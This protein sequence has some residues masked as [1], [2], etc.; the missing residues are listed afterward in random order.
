MNLREKMRNKSIGP[1]I[2]NQNEFEGEYID[3]ETVPEDTIKLN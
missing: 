3:C 2:G 1:L